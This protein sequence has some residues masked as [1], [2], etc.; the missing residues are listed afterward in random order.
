MPYS[1]AKPLPRSATL[2]VGR[3]C[4]HFRHILFFFFFI[5]SLFFVR[6]ARAGSGTMKVKTLKGMLSYACSF[7]SG[8]W[9]SLVRRLIRS[10][11]SHTVDISPAHHLWSLRI[12][13]LVD[14]AFMKQRRVSAGGIPESGLDVLKF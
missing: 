4:A 13:F 8:E 9:P 11:I 7:E 6:A 14:R 10:L 1:P 12:S 2:C 3:D 5:F